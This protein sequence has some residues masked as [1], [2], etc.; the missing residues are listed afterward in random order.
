MGVVVRGKRRPVRPDSLHV[1]RGQDTRRRILDAARTRVLAGG[2]EA[3][4]LD[5]L[6]RDVGVTKAAVIKSVGGKAS[7]LLS[8]LEQDRESRLEVLRQATKLRSGLRRRV[9]DVVSRLYALDAPRLHL[10]Q[11]YV[12]YL[13]FW[14]G[15]DHERAQGHVDGTLETLRDFVRS[16]AG[17][18]Q[19]E[20]RIETLALRMM[21]GYV[22][23]LRDLHYGRS[24]IAE[25]TELVV[26]FVAE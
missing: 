26:D 20:Q 4:R 16:A 3:L 12:G 15:A 24:D 18:D 1:L 19:P 17:A 2:F 14:T 13:W 10:V 5:D 25:A 11:A 22:I 6:A 23:G 8:L 21:A 7:I 9:A